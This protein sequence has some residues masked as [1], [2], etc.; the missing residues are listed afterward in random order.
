MSLNLKEKLSDPKRRVSIDS[1]FAINHIGHKRWDIISKNIGNDID[2]WR[3][4]YDIGKRNL[5]P[6]NSHD[7]NKSQLCCG[8][9]IY[10]GIR[11]LFVAKGIMFDQT[12]KIS[13]PKKKGVQPKK[14]ISKADKIKQ[15]NILRKI[16][17]DVDTLL[18]STTYD[19]LTNTKSIVFS[20]KFV[21]LML[22]RMMMHCKNLLS[23][24]ESLNKKYASISSSKYTAKEELEELRESIQ[25]QNK[26]IAE[27]IVGYNKIINE[28]QDNTILSHT[29]IADLSNWITHA[30]K[31]IN[32]NASEII[33]NMP[34]LIFKTIYDGMLE[35]KQSGLYQSQKEIFE[36]VTKNDK[37]LALV[38][39]MLGS[40]KTSMVLPLCGWLSSN[41]KSNKTKLIFCCPNEVVLLEVAHMVYGMGVSFAIVIRNQSDHTLEYKWS[42]FAD[43][44]K[45]K[46][47]AVLYLCDI[48]VARMLL[49]ERM[50]CLATKKLYMQANRRDPINY[51]L[52]EQRIPYVPDYILMG[53]ELT[54]DADTQKGFMIDSGFSVTTEVFVNLMKI[55]PPKVILMSAT[56]PT[57][58][59]L[60]EFYNA[61]VDS[62]PGM[63]V[64][65]FAS[66]EA[67][68]GCALISSSGEL[69]APHMGCETVSDIEHIL[70][71]IRTNPF[72]GRFYTFEVLLQMVDIFK[73]LSLHVPDLS[74][75]YDNPSKAN[76]TNIQQTAYAMLESLIATKSNELISLACKLKKTVGKGVD[77]TTILT[78]DIG[79]FNKGCLVFSSDPVATAF[80]VYR[81][82]FDKFLDPKS[83]RTV[84]QQ[85]RLDTIL[86]KYQREMD[87]W[88]KALRRIE[89]KTDDGAIK[90]NKENNKKER[91]KTDTWQ[92]SAKMLDQKPH[93]DFPSELQLCSIE[94]LKKSKFNGN[95]IGAGGMVG[96]DDLPDST[97]VS[98]DILTM[99]ASGIGIYTTNST[100]L[101]DEYLKTVLLLAKKGIVKVIFTDSSIAYGTN[102]A[103]SDIIMIDEPVI[104]NGTDTI[105]SIVDQHSMKT[106]FQMLGRAGRGGNLSYEARIYTTSAENNLI[107]R[108]RSYAK[109][110]LDEGCKDE[111]YN[112]RRA[113]EMLW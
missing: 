74:I 19:N 67:K 61:I 73:Q 5:V 51:P 102:L 77:L 50:Q 26:V 101:D 17:T 89:E 3:N 71:I 62:N 35:H 15:D 27:L 16:K 12:T 42:S 100:V 41:R 75:M 90:Q 91:T 34:E 81:A 54:K 24:Y 46:E 36:F 96:P 97:S 86:S 112:I 14:Q 79:R 6:D 20:A 87:S 33:I 84:F 2:L 64:K 7:I 111:I 66:S 95:T 53:D 88:K 31:L 98:M 56:L 39:T 11:P 10:L 63:I 25:N 28:K 13:M 92:S 21:E 38:H 29:C 47:S 4:L 68:I 85:V 52:I 48:F 80:N 105:D 69:Y 59:Q 82:N 9:E 22:I 94:H 23:E 83:E 113:F 60:P 99:L 40:G 30:K 70:S 1:K 44:D 49:E 110:T 58:E 106:I 18:K 55:A 108:I 103:V 93:W 65:S 57:A 109:G 72:I 104:S 76:Q 78:S 107:D 8:E 45:P 37:Y 43:K 32:F